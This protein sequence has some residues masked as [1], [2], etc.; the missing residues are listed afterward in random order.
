MALMRRMA[1]EQSFAVVAEARHSL[2]AAAT[3]LKNDGA[4]E[5]TIRDAGNGHIRCWR[6][7]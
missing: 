2:S 7:S 3:A 1:K 6:L 4:G 5:W